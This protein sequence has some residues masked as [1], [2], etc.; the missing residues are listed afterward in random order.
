MDNKERQID[1]QITFSRKNI[2]LFTAFI[3]YIVVNLII[4]GNLKMTAHVTIPCF[5]MGF[6][7]L[8]DV[9]FALFK[10]FHNTNFLRVLKFLELLTVGLLIGYSSKNTGGAVDLFAIALFMFLCVQF[11]YV[12]NLYD[13]SSVLIISFIV[14]TPFLAKIIISIIKYAPDMYVSFNYFAM[15]CVMYVIVFAIYTYIC[16]I[17]NYNEQCLYSKDRMLDSA[18]DNYSKITENQTK[19]MT[20]NELLSVKKFELEEAY[21]KINIINEDI[22]FQN[23]ILKIA[24]STLEFNKVINKCSDAIIEKQNDVFY[25]GVLFRDKRYN[26]NFSKQLEKMLNPLELTEFM[27]FFLSDA[28]R[29]E[30]FSTGIFYVNNEVSYDEFP[31]LERIEARSIIVKSLKVQVQSDEYEC[32]YIIMSKHINA[33]LGK[34]TVYDNILR[35]IEAA[36]NNIFMY[37]K[38]K[39]LSNRDGLSGLY[40]RRYLNLY[41]DEHFIKSTTDGTAIAALLDIDHFKKINDTYGHLF[42]D[43]AIIM[44]A[45]VV[46]SIAAQNDGITFRYGGEEFVVLFENISLQDGVTIM[47]RIRQ[48]IK[49]TPIVYDNKTVYVNVSVGVSGYP[50]TTKDLSVLIDRADKAMYYSKNNGRDRLTVDNESI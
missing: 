6:V 11:G 30:Q 21:R 45:N 24:S 7:M 42:G 34:E 12:V 36:A 1:L 44:V 28:F 18:K 47:E 27:N 46:S 4:Q 32:A 49:E 17:Q 41:Y 29:D 19:M 15:A 2:G 35:Q 50:D 43:Q 3:S 25:A 20:A 16:A 48:S 14:Q 5:I 26:R 10:F 13:N 22:N 37:S 31:F 38:I 40:N 33:F 8:I 23:Q 9:I 39:E